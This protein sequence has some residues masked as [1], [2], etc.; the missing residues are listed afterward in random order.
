MSRNLLHDNHR[1]LF[2]EASHGPTVIDNNIML[3]RTPAFLNAQGVAYMH[4]LMVGKLEINK[5]DGRKT[6]VLVPHGTA[7]GAAGQQNFPHGD[8]RFHNNLFGPGIRLSELPKRRMPDV[9][10]GNVYLG[11]AKP[12][13]DEPAPV[14]LEADP[15]V[16][17][18]ARPDG[19]YLRMTCDPAL[20]AT[21]CT[22]LVTTESLGLA[23]LPEQAYTNPDGSP[24][25]IDTDYFGKPRDESNPT[26]GPFE[27]PGT[28]LVILKVWNAK[29]K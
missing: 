1:D 10:A 28:G 17:L 19:L 22:S 25:K 23:F 12:R 27:N 29:G 24:L 16:S 20:T 7:E 21:R 11:G 5:A 15:K 14:V 4:N 6:P 3:S 9:M 18:E 8:D 13:D 2:I 26:P